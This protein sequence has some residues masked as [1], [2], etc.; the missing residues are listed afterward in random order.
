MYQPCHPQLRITPFKV[1]AFLVLLLFLQQL[2]VVPGR[3]QLARALNNA[4]HVPF[5]F[6]V[7]FVIIF[8][9][10]T[11]PANKSRQVIFLTSMACIALALATEMIQ[12]FTGRDA[13]IEDIVRDLLGIASAILLYSGIQRHKQKQRFSIMAIVM[14]LVLLIS[15]FLQVGYIT[16]MYHQRDKAAPAL[17]MME[18]PVSRLGFFLRGD[19][20]KVGGMEIEGRTP[21]ESMVKVN[22]HTN[23]QY[24][25]VMI[26]E[27][28]PDWSAYRNIILEGYLEGLHDMEQQ[29]QQEQQ[30]GLPLTLRVETV[31][32]R[33]MDTIF[34]TEI[35]SGWLRMEVPV[36][37][38]IREQEGS[39][40]EVRNLLIYTTVNDQNLSLYISSLRLE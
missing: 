38:L 17:L 24:P 36:R 33:G 32:D 12:Y 10:H 31:R 18:M 7:T 21:S 20:E 26:R 9:V 1:S 14:S 3:S 28:L 19:W 2:L 29:E 8:L 35:N 34:E 27:L 30:E 16:W 40:P 23:R 22:L 39:L 4:L 25:G 13:S 11:F 37:S 5:F 6:L 15:G